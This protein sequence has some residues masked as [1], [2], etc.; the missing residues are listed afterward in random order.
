MVVVWTLTWFAYLPFMTPAIPG[1]LVLT[2]LVIARLSV[3]KQQQRRRTTTVVV[4]PSEVEWRD[5]RPN[6]HGVAFEVSESGNGQT[7]GSSN[8]VR[9]EPCAGPTRPLAIRRSPTPLA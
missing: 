1:A 8:R 2:W 4:A 6:T 9:R 5:S 3:R 7:I